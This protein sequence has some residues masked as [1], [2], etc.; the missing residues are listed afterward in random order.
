LTGSHSKPELALLVWQ[1]TEEGLSQREIARRLECS[2]NT[3]ST[4]LAKDPVAL[5]SARQ[6]LR[7]ERAQRWKRIESMGLDETIDWLIEVGKLRTLLGG[8]RLPASAKCRLALAATIPS[9]LRAVQITA[10]TATRQV[11]LLT[12]GATE[13]VDQRTTSSDS[14]ITADQ[15]IQLAID[16][17][18]PAAIQALPP[19]LRAKAQVVMKGGA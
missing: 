4:I 11:Q 16:L 12:G 13:R 9:Y 10:A 18:D 1:F 8:K 3:V 7:E 5:E 19:N 14:E 17:G 15:L 6:R 2:T